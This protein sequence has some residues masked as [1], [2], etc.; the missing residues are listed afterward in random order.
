[1]FCENLPQ[2]SSF[3]GS[4]CSGNQPSSQCPLGC[5]WLNGSTDIQSTRGQRSE[6][7][8]QLH[9]AVSGN[10][11][12]LCS[13]IR[14]HHPAVAITECSEPSSASRLGE[15]SYEQSSHGMSY[16][17]PAVFIAAMQP[18]SSGLHCSY[19]AAHSPRNRPYSGAT[20]IR[21]IVPTFSFFLIIIF[22]HKD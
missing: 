21:M 15:C 8:L 19:A 12:G 16:T 22:N 14:L 20:D 9:L 11:L 6:L 3:I 1:M 18:D 10:Q 2:S 17:S 4:Q 5:A 7:K 13:V